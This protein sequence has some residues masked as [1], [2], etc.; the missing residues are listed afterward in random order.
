MSTGDGRV[1]GTTQIL[2]NGPAT[3]RFNIVIMGDGY[4]SAQLAQFATNV[5]GFVNAL[6]STPPFDRLKPAINVFRVD[7][8]S[9]DAGADD[10]AA[11]GGSGA[12][13]RTYFDATF[14]TNGIGRLLT[15][16]NATAFT[17][18]AAQVPQF[19]LIMVLVNTPIY[20]GS[21]GQIAVQSLAL[22]AQEIALHEMGHTA[23][24]LADEYE[25]WKG[26]G[27]DAPGTHD[28]HP[29]GEP[30]KPNVTL[31]P[32]AAKWSA[33]IVPGTAM[34]T[35]RNANCAQCD[36][37][38]N[39]VGVGVV[40]AFEGADYYH[41]GAYR[42]MFTCRM[43]VLGNPFCAVCELAIKKTLTPFLPQ[44]LRTRSVR[45]NS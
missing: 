26:C 25:Y 10:P 6:V 3:R 2:N 29:A 7:V 43:R 27:V 42:P 31:D 35:T 12:T 28:H 14:C 19:H 41:C 21:G 20:G 4:Q 37:K 45:S 39:P 5:Q 30:T 16:N 15:V 38:G 23:F 32:S 44:P 11:C 33:L 34:P 18:A 8:E 9:T 13:P 1:V 40:G 36:P 17:V 24:G 22:G